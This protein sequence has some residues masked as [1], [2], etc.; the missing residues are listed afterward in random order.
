M[1]DIEKELNKIKE[2]IKNIENKH[3]LVKDYKIMIYL[4][5]K[6]NKDII[7]IPFE[8]IENNNSLYRCIRDDVNK[9]YIIERLKDDK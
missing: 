3:L 4:L 6:L 9:K 7:E 2:Q 5:D 8:E 1:E